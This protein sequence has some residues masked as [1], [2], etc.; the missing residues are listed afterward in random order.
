MGGAI[1]YKTGKVGRPSKYDIKNIQKLIPA[2]P[3]PSLMPNIL[4]VTPGNPATP[5][6]PTSSSS[7]VSACPPGLPMDQTGMGFN[8]S[9]YL[10]SSFSKTDSITT[11][12]VSSVKNGLPP[13][14]P[15]TE[16]I[17]LYQKYIARSR[18]TFPKPP[19]PPPPPPYPEP[20]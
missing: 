15:V 12:T 19:P 9:D 14:K 20:P 2:R 7:A 10:K 17:N 5:G 3:D 16:D 13:E 11:G 4:P 8:T 18:Q 6:A 1:A